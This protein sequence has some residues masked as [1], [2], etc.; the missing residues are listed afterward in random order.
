MMTV[1]EMMKDANLEPE[2][3]NQVIKE[4]QKAGKKYN[5][6]QCAVALTLLLR[7]LVK[8]K[9]QQQI[10]DAIVDSYDVDFSDEGEE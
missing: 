8:N 4:F 5:G 10:I 6:I 1:E 9:K 2:T 7:T 3:I